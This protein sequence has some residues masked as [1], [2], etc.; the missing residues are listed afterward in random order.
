M[1]QDVDVAVDVKWLRR[2]LNMHF[3]PRV[4]CIMLQILWRARDIVVDHH[5]LVSP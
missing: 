2:V 3:D 5:Y 4:A 1:E